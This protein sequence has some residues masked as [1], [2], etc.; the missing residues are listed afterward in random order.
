MMWSDVNTKL[1]Y[2]LGRDSEAG[3]KQL[4]KQ[5]MRIE[6][7][8]WVQDV[9]V[10][11]TPRQ[12]SITLTIESGGRTA[13]LPEDLYVVDRI[14]DSSNEKF[15]RPTNFYPGDI[16]YTDDDVLQFW[17]WDNTLTLESQ[18]ATTSTDLTLYYWAYYPKVEY[19]LDG[20]TV[21]VEQGVI[22]TPR[23]AELALIHLTAASVFMPLE[24]EASDLNQWKIKVESGNPLQNPRAQSA[25][26]HL[27][28]YDLL[29]AK[30]PKSPLG[31]AD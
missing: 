27:Q 18:L 17:I 26:Y 4:K 3:G 25:L 30:F 21:L 5:E 10:H 16:R 22:Y 7:W 23:W 6:S 28:W 12:R 15:W 13:N 2:F 24:I 29:T 20:T 1:N 14:Y 11:H 8:N 19:S 31:R 9:F